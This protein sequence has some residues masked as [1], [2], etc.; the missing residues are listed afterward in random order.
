MRCAIFA[1][2]MAAALCFLCGVALEKEIYSTNKR[3][4]KIERLLD[5]TKEGILPICEALRD[6]MHLDEVRVTWRAC[7]VCA[8]LIAALGAS[9]VCVVPRPAP[10]AVFIVLFFISISAF[11]MKAGYDSCHGSG[12]VQS[13]VHYLSRVLC[14]REQPSSAVKWRQL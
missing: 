9:L 11:Y 1:V 12:Y 2:I 13:V 6:A 14:D 10:L 7:A 8:F 5:E 3:E 4:N